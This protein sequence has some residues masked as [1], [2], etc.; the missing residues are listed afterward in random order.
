MTSTTKRWGF[1]SAIAMMFLGLILVSIQMGH[2]QGSSLFSQV[3][4]GVCY[5]VILAWTGVFK[6][7]GVEGDQGLGYA[8]P[9]VTS[10]VL[11]FGCLG[12]GAGLLLKR[13]FKR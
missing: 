11:Y 13:I 10:I 8:L 4:W 6:L 1:G 12:F 3:F 5:P 9:M 2:P 7:L